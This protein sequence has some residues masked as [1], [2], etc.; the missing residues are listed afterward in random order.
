MNL[1]YT[2][3]VLVYSAVLFSASILA[4]DPKSETLC[5][6]LLVWSSMATD[7]I[8]REALV[9]EILLKDY[10]ILKAERIYDMVG[11]EVFRYSNLLSEISESGQI[12]RKTSSRIWDRMKSDLRGG[13]ENKTYRKYGLSRKELPVV[14]SLIRTIEAER[15]LEVAVLQLMDRYLMASLPNLKNVV[16]M[17]SNKM[18]ATG[19]DWVVSPIVIAVAPFIPETYRFLG[20]SFHHAFTKTKAAK[21][22]L[23]KVNSSER[24]EKSDVLGLAKNKNAKNFEELRARLR[25]GQEAARL[26]SAELAS[27]YDREL[28]RII[29]ETELLGVSD[30]EAFAHEELWKSLRTFLEGN[31]DIGRANRTL[32]LKKFDSYLVHVENYV[33]SLKAQSLLVAETQTVNLLFLERAH[34][35][36]SRLP[37]TGE[38]AGVFYQKEL[39]SLVRRLESRESETEVVQASLANWLERCDQAQQSLFQLG[40]MT[41]PVLA[42]GVSPEQL[43]EKENALFAAVGLKPEPKKAWYKF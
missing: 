27:V 9:A 1:G 21:E 23:A 39:E 16:A 18:K 37:A 17:H 8:E 3:Q 43:V 19:G 2:S 15:V 33:L 31:R 6:R 25:S 12:L 14:L 24:E 10:P 13:P 30:H 28:Q 26:G 22:V 11:A 34:S 36:I 38:P 20:N 7:D 5:T 29:H 40:K 41:N 42:S 4:D 32:L 35:E